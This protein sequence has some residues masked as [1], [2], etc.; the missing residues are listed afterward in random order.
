MIESKRESEG[1]MVGDGG[2]ERKREKKL[3][4]CKG[5]PTGLSADFFSRNFIG[6]KRVARHIQSAKKKIPSTNTLPGKAVIQN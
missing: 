2:R 6:Q 5:S 3:I 1:E 4:M